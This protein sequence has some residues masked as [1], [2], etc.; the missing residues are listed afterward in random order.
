MFYGTVAKQAKF[1]SIIALG[2]QYISHQ[3]HHPGVG[4]QPDMSPVLTGGDGLQGSLKPMDVNKVDYRLVPCDAYPLPI[5]GS[6]SSKDS[7]VLGRLGLENKDGVLGVKGFETTEEAQGLLNLRITNELVSD[8]WLRHFLRQASSKGIYLNQLDIST[9]DGKKS[10][11][12]YIIQN[13]LMKSF[14]WLCK[15][16]HFNFAADQ[17]FEDKMGRVETAVQLAAKKPNRDIFLRNL[18]DGAFKLDN[19][20]AI[21]LLIEHG[22]D[23]QLLKRFDIKTFHKQWLAGAL[24]SIIRKSK[25][26]RM[27]YIEYIKKSINPNDLKKALGTYFYYE[28]KRNRSVHTETPMEF[29]KKY[30]RTVVL[31]QLVDFT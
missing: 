4:T 29:A 23:P 1:S 15:S 24:I 22:V 6:M 30:N 7:T 18:P 26:E 13:E 27:P 9:D 8:D 5:P 12:Y 25:E 11:S 17:G 16:K 31:K 10:V 2:L 20:K 3:T 28:N 21:L 19:G 14:A